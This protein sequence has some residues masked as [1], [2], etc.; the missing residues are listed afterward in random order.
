LY[1]YQESHSK[2]YAA[3][4]YGKVTTNLSALITTFGV[5]ELSALNAIA[6]SYSEYVPVV[7]IVGCPSTTAQKDKLL[8]HHTLGNGDFNVFKSMAAPV[9]VGIAELTDAGTAAEKIDEVLTRAWLLSRP[10]YVWLPTDLVKQE[11]EGARLEEIPLKIGKYVEND[12][13]K[14]KYV[15]EVVLKHLTEAKNPMVLVDACTMRHRAVAE[16]KEFIEASKLPFCTS[17]M[18]KGALDETHPQFCGVYAGSVTTPALKERIESSDLVLAVGAIKSDFNTAGFTYQISKLQTID[19]HSHG[20]T[21][22][23]SEYPGVRM[24]GVLSH[25]AKRI[26]SEK[27]SLTIVPGPKYE[28]PEFFDTKLAEENAKRFGAET[29]THDFMWRTFTKYLLPGDVI[30]TET[31]TSN[32]GIMETGFPTDARAVNQYLWGSIGYAA[33]ASQGAAHAVR[34]LKEMGGSKLGRTILWTGEG[35]FQLTLQ[36]VATVLRNDLDLIMFVI[37]NDGFVFISI[38]CSY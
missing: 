10:V 25:L 31:G 16:V 19:F 1:A 20:I 22:K 24:N 27:I 9:A 30:V 11:V 26:T 37:N 33:P 29:I 4:G 32:C 28:V 23:Y 12:T 18:G 14:E 8:L 7:H 6:G 35:S 21:V 15:T 2:G 34:D 5:G 38:R 36:C 17:P 13:E 3:D